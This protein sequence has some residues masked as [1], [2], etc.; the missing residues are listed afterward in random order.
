MNTFS[1]KGSIKRGWELWKAN[2]WVLTLSTILILLVGLIPN[3]T[4]GGMEKLFIEL[5]VF[6]A[7]TFVS[8]GYL[9][10]LLMIERGEKVE[11]QDLF[12]HTKYFGRYVVTSLLYGVLIGVG[13][14][15]LLIP[16]IYLAL[17]YSQAAMLVLDKDVRIGEAFTKSGMMTKG[18]KWKL[19]GFYLSI[20]IVAL[21]GFLAL[22]VGVLITV[23]VAS[24]AVVVVYRKLLESSE[25]KTVA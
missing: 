24:L 9:K 1:V 13:L 21:L 16:G 25:D 2:K 3:P 18:V 17:K 19:V 12:G 4:E 22:G 7:S 5:I 11:F 20:I 14:I 23:P 6:V 15:L 10:S 8:M